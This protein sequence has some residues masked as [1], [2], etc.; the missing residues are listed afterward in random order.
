MT[1]SFNY[2]QTGGWGEIGTE[3]LESGERQ[4]PQLLQFHQAN[5][6]RF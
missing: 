6:R 1:D 5:R 4:G 2:D 3:S